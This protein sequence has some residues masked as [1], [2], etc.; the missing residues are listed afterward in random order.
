M[1][2]A[3]ILAN[4]EP[5]PREALARAVGAAALF[6]CADGG[7]NAARAF[8]LAPQAIVGDLDSA[9]PETLA[10]FAAVPVVREPDTE[11]TDLEKTLEYVLARGPFA[12]IAVFGATA[13][14]LDHVL[15]HLSLLKRYLGRA[16]LVLEDA[17]G[18]AWLA[19]GEVE[20]DAP[21]GT[22]VSFFAVG[23]PAEG[24]TTEGLRY[25]LRGARLELGAQDSVSN[26]VE[27][28]PARIRVE[29]GEILV[30]V[31]TAP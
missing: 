10:H 22:T 9:L 17:H 31:V 28:R 16:P 26:V 24:V 11:R 19:R 18:R 29:R 4:G 1:R 15:G 14:R 3:V 12:E 20:L 21:P 23:A 27:R 6:V 7:A 13:G 2:T 25:P 8:G 5:P 30:L